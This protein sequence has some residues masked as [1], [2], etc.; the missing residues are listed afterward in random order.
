MEQ[1]EDSEDE[2]EQVFTFPPFKKNKKD[3][4]R[5]V[6]EEVEQVIVTS[7]KGYYELGDEVFVFPQPGKAKCSEKPVFKKELELRVQD[8]CSSPVKKA[9]MCDD[10]DDCYKDDVFEVAGL[11]IPQL[12]VTEDSE[13]AVKSEPSFVEPSFLEPPT[14][15]V[16]SP[17]L[18][19][20]SDGDY[21]VKTCI[22]PE[23]VEKYSTPTPPTVDWS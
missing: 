7:D 23:Y 4:L 17:Q 20:T 21:V 8:V 2:D 15:P 5:A 16:G 12:V 13:C 6:R 19:V 11:E 22:T 18:D 10:Y 3:A 14:S 9:K 1:V